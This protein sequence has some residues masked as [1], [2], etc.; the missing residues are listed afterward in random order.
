M[1]KSRV[2]YICTECGFDTI[3]WVGKCPQC[4]NWN[5]FAEEIIEEVKNKRA[6]EKSTSE[7]IP[8]SRQPDEDETRL[9]TMISEFDRVLGGGIV[10][11]SVILLG[12]D[13]GIG[14]STLIM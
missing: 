5:T 1:A 9:E 11:G 13:P 10:A 14:K 3:K 6:V 2:K 4:E 12:G 7:I 8:L